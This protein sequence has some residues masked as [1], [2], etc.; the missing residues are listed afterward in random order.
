MRRGASRGGRG[1]EGTYL[2][3]GYDPPRSSGSRANRRAMEFMRLGVAWKRWCIRPRIM[4]LSRPLR[5]NG[6]RP[7]N[8]VVRLRRRRAI[9]NYLSPDPRMAVACRIVS[10]I[11][12]SRRYI[13]ARSSPFSSFPLVTR[14][15]PH[16]FLLN[17]LW[18]RWRE[19]PIWCYLSRGF[20]MSYT[21]IT[22]GWCSDIF[23]RVPR[24]VNN[25]LYA[26]RSNPQVPQYNT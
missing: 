8:D 1:E 23:T 22:R 17:P 4:S 14:F 13:R 9:G 12:L 3:I 2:K 16:Q 20:T 7:A 21:D 19:S 18:R 6:S 24:N 10:W 5:H 26:Q 25:A 15:H 11:V